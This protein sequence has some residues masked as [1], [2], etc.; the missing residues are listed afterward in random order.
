MW[1]NEV[2]LLYRELKK[3]L[4]TMDQEYCLNS[5]KEIDYDELFETYMPR[6]ENFAHVSR[7]KLQS[8]N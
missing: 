5:W 2:E 8:F 1:E 3:I 6:V 7:Q 4:K